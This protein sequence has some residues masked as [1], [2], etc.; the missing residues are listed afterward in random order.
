MMKPFRPILALLAVAAGGA[1]TQLGPRSVVADR[2][3]YS[4]S[5]ADSWKRQTLLNIVKMRYMDLPV[6][7]DVASIVAGYSLETSGSV[8]GQL[9][10]PEAVQGD[11]LLLGAAARYTD[12]PTVT[13][14]PMTGEK[15]MRGLLAPID[16]KNIFFMLQ[17]GYAADFVLA[18]SVESLNGL[19]N[20]TTVAGSLRDADPAFLRALELLRELQAAGAFG[21][22]VEEAKN[23]QSTTVL[24]LERDNLP[25]GLQAKS[26]ELRRLLSLP[27]QQSD[28]ILRYSPLRAKPGELAVS[29]RSMLQ[30]MGAFATYIDVPQEHVRDQSALPA[31]EENAMQASQSRIRIHSGARCPDSAYA[32]VKYRGHW[33]W[34]EEGDWQTKRAL[35]AVMYFFT[36]AETGNPDRLP[37]VTIP[38][39]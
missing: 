35:T 8:G 37:M 25:A 10:T 27:E 24:F 14:V 17:A 15:F 6:F 34:V 23:K 5:I 28:F 29:S 39:Q 16:P 1:C 4:S 36:L 31:V 32:S 22:R 30:I 11:S 13:Y 20:R 33:F 3:D 19:R 9:S 2:F 12:R 18:L 21:M 38:A 7:V 26:A